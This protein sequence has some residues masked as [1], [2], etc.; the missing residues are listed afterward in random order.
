[1][2]KR[3]NDLNKRFSQTI[4]E[5]RRRHTNANARICVVF[6]DIET[7]LL[8]HIGDNHCKYVAILCPYFSNQK[9]LKALSTKDGVSIVT[10]YDKNLKSKVRTKS[11]K[12][13]SPLL[14]DRVRTLNCGTGK[15]K[16]I[17]HSK[18]IVLLDY[19]KRPYRAI[20]GSYNFS[21]G[22]ETNIETMT[23]YDNAVVAKS[24][25]DEFFRVYGISKKYL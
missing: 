19:E 20:G 22:S 11:F 23:V 13:L 4:Q 3:K 7:K 2:S 18:V 17:M 10:T 15:S 12:E 6:D 5:K 8:E 1:M 25:Y 21:G 24:F 16:S 14:E 9:I